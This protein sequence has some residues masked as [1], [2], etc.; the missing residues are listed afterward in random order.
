MLRGW[1]PRRAGADRG[2]G[3]G[4]ISPFRYARWFLTRRS[5]CSSAF[6]FHLPRFR[7]GRSGFE[8]FVNVAAALAGGCEFGGMGEGFA[9]VGGGVRDLDA[10]VIDV[11]ECLGFG[12]FQ[13]RESVL[14]TVR[15]ENLVHLMR[16][17]DIR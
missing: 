4:P 17:G 5:R 16:P 6:G 14:Q 1:R 7:C 3:N 9:E 13:A 10:G 12:G 8:L 15:A 11:G 2:I